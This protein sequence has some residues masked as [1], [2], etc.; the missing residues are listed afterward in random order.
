MERKEDEILY[1]MDHIWVPLVEGVRTIIL[2]EAHK[3][4]YS[5][6]LGADKMYYDLRDMYW[7]SSIKKDMATSPVLW[8]KIGESRLI[9][10]ELVQETTNKV[11]LIKENLEAT[12]DRQKSYADNSCKPLEFKVGDKVLLKLSP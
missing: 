6:H 11:V 10:L 5:M 7:W 4:R 3:T 8:A 12:R 9:G 2:D 1:F